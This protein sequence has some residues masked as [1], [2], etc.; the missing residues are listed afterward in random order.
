MFRAGY[1]S[2]S[3]AEDEASTVQLSSDVGRINRHSQKCAVKLQEIGPRM[4]LQLVKV[5]EGLCSGAVIFHEYSKFFVII[6]YYYLY[7]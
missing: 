2:E 7:V 3:E 4:T 1:G 5:E 6:M